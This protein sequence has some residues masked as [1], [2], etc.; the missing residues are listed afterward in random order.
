MD[1]GKRYTNSLEILNQCNYIDPDKSNARDFILSCIN[2]PHEINPMFDNNCINMS[3]Q[4]NDTEGFSNDHSSHGP[5]ISYTPLGTCHDGYIRDEKGDCILQAYR[6]RIRDGDWQRGNHAETI[7]DGKENYNI[8]G[9]GGT[10]LGLSDGN[11]RCEKKEGV[12]EPVI[13]GFQGGS[14]GYEI[15]IEKEEADLYQNL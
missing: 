9:S 3:I 5:G 2:Q 1:I 11:P 7:H 10:F 6:G 12:E 14:R 15:N 8:C 4:V 13:E